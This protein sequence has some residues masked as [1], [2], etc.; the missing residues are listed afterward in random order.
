MIA[1]LLFT[2]GLLFLIAAAVVGCGP[3]RPARAPARCSRIYGERC[4]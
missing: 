4:V 1:D 3:S 2:L